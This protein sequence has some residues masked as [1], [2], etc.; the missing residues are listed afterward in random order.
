M[1]P[2]TPTTLLSPSLHDVTDLLRSLTHSTYAVDLETTSLDAWSPDTYVTSIGI[3]GPEGCYAVLLVNG[4]SPMVWHA[5]LRWLDTV[6]LT[7]FNVAFDGRVLHAQAGHWHRWIMCSLL[8]F[9]YLANEGW[10]GQ[11]W[12]LETLEERVLG[13]DMGHKSR[14][15][16]LLDV[17]GLDKSSMSKLATL[18]PAEFAH[19]NAW[20]AEAAWQAYQY[21]GQLAQ[22]Q[23]SS[24][25]ST[26]VEQHQREL[27]TLCRLLSESNLN[28]IRINRRKLDQYLSS[29]AQQIQ[30]A[31]QTLIAHP[32]VAPWVSKRLDDAIKA[33]ADVEPPKFTKAGT[34]T[35]RWSKWNEQVKTSVSTEEVINFGSPKQLHDL[36]YVHLGNPVKVRTK[37]GNPATDKDALFHMGEVGR[38]L[39]SYNDVC[40]RYTYAQSLEAVSDPVTGVFHPDFK[41]CGA[42]S[43]R[44]SGGKDES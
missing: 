5:I 23:W 11:R 44:L 4:V 29:L 18:E 8:A 33:R 9:R 16:E 35:K 12:S 43:G 36:L 13:W 10:E 3:A 26:F 28:G 19:Y 21:F 34:I 27:M 40:K 31:Y 39:R 20:D 25:G 37:K 7:A 38:L 14:L 41:S 24:W 17:H 1:T 42:V 30:S 22:S 32:D 2:R 6:K 15:D